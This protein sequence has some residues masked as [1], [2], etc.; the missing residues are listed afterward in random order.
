MYNW[1]LLLMPLEICPEN[2]LGNQTMP[3]KKRQLVL[4]YCCQDNYTHKSIKSSEPAQLKGNFYYWVFSLKGVA[5]PP[6][7]K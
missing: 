4:L 2:R 3:L 5:S 7:P 1:T 6:P